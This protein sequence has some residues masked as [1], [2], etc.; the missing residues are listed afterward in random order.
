MLAAAPAHAATTIICVNRPDDTDCGPRPNTIPDALTLAQGDG[1]DSVIR[2]GP[3]TYVDGPYVFDGTVSPLTVQGSNNGAG[4]NAT[5]LKGGAAAP[6]ATATNVT[7]RNLRIEV[8]G[9]GAQGLTLPVPAR[10]P[11][12]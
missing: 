1:T 2:I 3:G 8:S 5:L 11:R 7:I 12:T 9:S 6:Y 10:S 4:A